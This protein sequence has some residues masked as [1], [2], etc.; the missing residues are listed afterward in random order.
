M[1]RPSAA[2]AIVDLPDPDSPTSATDSPSRTSIDTSCAASTVPD[3]TLYS[4]ESD[5]ICNGGAA[6]LFVIVSPAG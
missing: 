4:I 1:A 5:S 6:S 2:R 3:G